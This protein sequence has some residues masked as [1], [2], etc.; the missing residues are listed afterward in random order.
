MEDNQNKEEI[1][2][3][4]KEKR[5]TRDYAWIAIGILFGFSLGVATKN[6]LI[7]IGFGLGMGVCFRK[8]NCFQL[9]RR[10]C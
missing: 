4:V 2:E 9:G 7:G 8:S 3:E 1:V 10:L 5:S 6:A